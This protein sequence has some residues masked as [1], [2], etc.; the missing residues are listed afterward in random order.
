MNYKRGAASNMH[1]LV[2]KMQNK[3][4]RAVAKAITMVE[5]DHPDKLSLLSDV[6]SFTRNA[7]YIGITGSPGAGKSSLVNQMITNIL[8]KNLTLAVISVDPMSNL[9]D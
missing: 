8:S 5:N 3:E 2:E 1:E 7:R 4:I 9:L 6:F